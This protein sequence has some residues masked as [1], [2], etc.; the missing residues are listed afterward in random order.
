MEPYSI[1]LNLAKLRE[2]KVYLLSHWRIILDDYLLL[3]H[4][5]IF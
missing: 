2:V 3:N 1:V 5:I 4:P